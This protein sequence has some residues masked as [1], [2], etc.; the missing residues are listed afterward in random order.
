MEFVQ[1]TDLSVIPQKIIFNFDEIKQ[2]L[3]VNLEKYKNMVVEEGAIKEAKAERAKINKLKTALEDKR[4]EIKAA[5]L[6]PYNDF[7]VEI[8]Q[9]TG[10][11]DEAMSVIDVQTKAFDDKE[12]SDKK[13]SLESFYKANAKTLQD[14]IS[15]ERIFNPKWLNKT[16][17]QITATQEIMGIIER[18]EKDTNEIDGLDHA[19][20]LQVKDKY[21]QTLDLSA[22]LAEGRRIAEVQ[23]ALEEKAAREAKEREEATK[24]KLVQA[25]QEAD[26]KLPYPTN[27]EVAVEPAN[28]VN[29]VTLPENAEPIKAEDIIH[30]VNK[31]TINI[32]VTDEQRKAL[33]VYLRA[34]GIKYELYKGE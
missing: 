12:K 20:T 17:A 34:N 27:T 28:A 10:M 24:Q 8:K 7:E 3:S 33:G 32:Y 4:K 14:V 18:I 30:I 6:A 23:K 5:C 2:N 13:A 31:M 21:F 11:M 15:F 9:L 26:Y 1:T 25:V 19:Y 22:A 16:V 29:Y